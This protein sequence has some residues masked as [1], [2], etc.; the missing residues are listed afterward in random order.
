[1]SRKNSPCRPPAERHKSTVSMSSSALAIQEFAECLF[2]CLGTA[3]SIEDDNAIC[4]GHVWQRP[5]DAGLVVVRR[6]PIRHD[7]DRLAIA[8]ASLV[9]CAPMEFLGRDV[10]VDDH[11]Q[12]MVAIR[13]REPNRITLRGLK[14]S[15]TACSRSAGTLRGAMPTL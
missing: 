11:Q 3:C 14:C 9:Q 4:L 1:M 10:V 8:P 5:D 7:V 12:V 2:G 13:A 15:T 6:L